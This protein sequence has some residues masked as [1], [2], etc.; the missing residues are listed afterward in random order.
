MNKI[1]IIN[2]GAGNFTSVWN[3]FEYL[4]IP[5]AEVRTPHEIEQSTHLVLPGVGSFEG[6]MRRLR[7]LHLEEGL[8]SAAEKGKPFLGICVGLQVLATRGLEFGVHAG[9]DLV[10]GEARPIR[11]TN[12]RLPHIGWNT[13]RAINASPLISEHED[14]VDFYFLHSFHLA[15][16]ERQHVTA[17]ADYGEEVTAIV[18]RNNV[19]GVQFHPEKSQSAGL[20]LLRRF[21]GLV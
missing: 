6:C 4:E 5:I 20:R 21:S 12:L 3:A 18:Q 9:L 10:P 1:G 14:E 13:C 8:S 2:Y 15:T 16:E 11:A 19:F 7:E 17:V